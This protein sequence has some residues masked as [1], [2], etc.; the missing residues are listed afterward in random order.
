MKT[1]IVVICVVLLVMLLI[2]T[3]AVV[4]YPSTVE[5]AMLRIEEFIAIRHD[6]IEEE[7]ARI[8]NE[9]VKSGEIRDEIDRP[10]DSR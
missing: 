9:K 4:F 10:E 1:T 7:K 5:S 6:A 3:P 2:A 8:T